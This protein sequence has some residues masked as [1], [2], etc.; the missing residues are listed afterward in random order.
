MEMKAYRV[1]VMVV[2]GMLLLVA[3]FHA[4]PA[5]ASGS[6]EIIA[7]VA[8]GTINDINRTYG[9]TTVAALD[10]SGTYLVRVAPGASAASVVLAM[11]ND[12]RLV[13]AILILLDALLLKMGLLAFAMYVLILVLLLN[14]RHFSIRPWLWSIPLKRPVP[15]WPV[16]CPGHPACRRDPRAWH[17]PDQLLMEVPPFFAE[18]QRPWDRRAP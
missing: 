7:R 11:Q 13:G 17:W 8:T 12:P 18:I 16:C 14:C 3:G 9:T 5:Y 1:F 10:N 15:L 2:V 6:D 4:A